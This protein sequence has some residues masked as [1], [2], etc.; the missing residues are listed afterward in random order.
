MLRDSVATENIST[1]GTAPKADVQPSEDQFVAVPASLLQSLQ[2]RIDALE[3]RIVQQDEKMAAL[4][5]TQDLHAENDLNQLRLIA[6]IRRTKEPT[7][8]VKNRQD[9]LR[10]LLATND[11]KM[12]SSMARKKMGVP[13]SSFW[14]LLKT[15]DF[16]EKRSYHLDP[17]QDVLVLI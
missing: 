5:A 7:E 17:R 11:G 4:D 2:D 14:E 8:S 6:D 10:A 13:K 12:L 16:I 3:D 9:I 1:F 15:C